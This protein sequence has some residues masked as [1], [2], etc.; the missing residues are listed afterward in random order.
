MKSIRFERVF[1]AGCACGASAV[2]VLCYLLAEKGVPLGWYIGIPCAVLVPILVW[3][4]SQPDSWFERRLA[5]QDDFGRKHP[6]V[7]NVALFA[8]LAMLVAKVIIWI[9][10]K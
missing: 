7:V 8:V 9:V 5:K 2:A 4:V 10:K 1:F 3:V 6:M